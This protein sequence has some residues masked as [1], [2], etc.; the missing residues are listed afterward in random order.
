MQNPSGVAVDSSGGMYIADFGNH[1]IRFVNATSGIVSNFAGTGTAA[2][3]GDNGAATSASLN[4]PYNVQMFF[5][6]VFISDSGNNVIRK[7]VIA[8][9]IITTIAGNGT[10]AL[11]GDGGAATSA[12]LNS[13]R[14]IAVAPT[15]VQFHCYPISGWPE[16]G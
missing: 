13:P 11:S 6:A 9:G 14:G 8:T 12:T 16:S 3:T 4:A 2:Y 5:G 1:I 7:V 15:S 10:A